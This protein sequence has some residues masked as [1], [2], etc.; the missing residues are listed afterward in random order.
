M[1]LTMVNPAAASASVE[2]IEV[3]AVESKAIIIVIILF[4]CIDHISYSS[5]WQLRR[6]WQL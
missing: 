6:P 1:K 2:L 5:L 3:A 4:R